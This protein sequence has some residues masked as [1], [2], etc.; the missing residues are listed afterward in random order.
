MATTLVWVFTIPPRADLTA[1]NNLLSK[2]PPPPPLHQNDPM[3]T[4]ADPAVSCL[5][6]FCVHIPC[7]TRSIL[8]GWCLLP[9]PCPL[10]NRPCPFTSPWCY[11][12]LPPAPLLGPTYLSGPPQIVPLKMLSGW[13]LLPHAPLADSDDSFV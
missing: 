2:P 7:W 9:S 3:V 10:G 4:Q 1:S 13:P 11:G 6:S 8:L 5:K 12:S